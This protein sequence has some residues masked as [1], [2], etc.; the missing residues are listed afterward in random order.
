V[1]TRESNYSECT[2]VFPPDQA[3]IDHR[4]RIFTRN[5]EAP[6]AGHPTIGTAFALAS[7]GAIGAG[8]A[9]TVF[10]LGVGPTPIDLEWEGARL[11]PVSTRRRRRS[12]PAPRFSSFLSRPCGTASCPRHARGG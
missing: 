1:L 11:W 7:T 3:G 12:A 5:A 8:T 10:G 9:R 2:F 6:F 4:V